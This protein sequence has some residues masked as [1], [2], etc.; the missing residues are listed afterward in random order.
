M[1]SLGP[2]LHHVWCNKM[3][4]SSLIHRQGELALRC[5]A[6]IDQIL[7]DNRD[8]VKLPPGAATKVRDNVFN[9]L[10]LL[11]AVATHFTIKQVRLLNLTIKCHYL[12]QIGF[13]AK[14]INPRLCWC[15]AGEDFMNKV[16]V[17]TQSCLKGTHASKVSEQLLPKYMVGLH[18]SIVSRSQL[19]ARVA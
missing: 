16:K 9:F 4:G 18:L 17:L 3:D 15:Y 13:H 7:D 1:R 14:Y 11:N 6:D 10:S 5:C 19:F 12:A 2:A 8:V